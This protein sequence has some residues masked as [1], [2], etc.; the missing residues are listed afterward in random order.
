MTEDF[1]GSVK[2]IARFAKAIGRRLCQDS[3]RLRGRRERVDEHKALAAV[4]KATTVLAALDAEAVV[5]MAKTGAA[6]AAAEAL[7][8]N[9]AG[10]DV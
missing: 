6:K 3:L 8:D 4:R 5:L 2:F 7:Q 1:E 9:F 10:G